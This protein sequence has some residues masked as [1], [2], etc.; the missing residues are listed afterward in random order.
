VGDRGKETERGTPTVKM[1][2]PCTY[3]VTVATALHSF[4]AALPGVG[5][6]HLTN[7]IAGLVSPERLLQRCERVALRGS[8]ASN[9]FP[10]SYSKSSA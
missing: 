10:S 5:P 6:L 7:V 1:H 9:P 2:H 4:A 3:V 8:L